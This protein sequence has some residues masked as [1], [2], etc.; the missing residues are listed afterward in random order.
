MF[1]FYF[2]SNIC[3]FSDIIE[4]SAGKETISSNILQTKLTNRFEDFEFKKL[5]LL[6]L[7]YL[8]KYRATVGII[9]ENNII[10]MLLDLIY[11]RNETVLWNMSQMWELIVY[12]FRVLS[13][14]AP[15]FS[16]EFIKHKATKM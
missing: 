13:F 4:L 14:L 3:S 9:K 15:K 11:P 8:V 2:T 5:L 1:T 6:A 10:R 16:Y 7:C 12:A